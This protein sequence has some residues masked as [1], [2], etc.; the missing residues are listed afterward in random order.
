MPSAPGS[1]RAEAAVPAPEAEA[2]AEL[3]AL[4]ETAGPAA[5]VLGAVAGGVSAAL[6]DAAPVT[7]GAGFGSFLSHAMIASNA[8]S[9]SPR[10]S[11]S[12]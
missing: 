4:A 11:T 9:A 10:R 8:S 7:L 5:E 1:S 12:G 2:A 3:E 6:A